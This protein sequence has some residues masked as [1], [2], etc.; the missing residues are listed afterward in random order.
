MTVSASTAQEE[1]YKNSD[2]LNIDKKREAD[3]EREKSLMKKLL[4]NWTKTMKTKMKNNEL[5][6]LESPI[7]MDTSN[8]TTRC[9]KMETFNPIH[10]THHPILRLA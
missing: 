10:S 8:R 4:Q 1:E 9:A 3:I 2:V 6:A 5:E 7:V